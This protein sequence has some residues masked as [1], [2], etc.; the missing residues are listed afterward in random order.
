MMN[1]TPALRKRRL[2]EAL[3]GYGF[4]LPQMAGFV[5]LVLIPLVNVFVYSFH[6]KN[7]LFGTNLFCGFDN[8][9]RLFSDPLFFL[10][11]KNTL[12]FSVFLVPINLALSLAL[13]LYLGEGR[14]GTRYIRTVIFLPV[15]TSGVAWSIVWI[16]LLQGG[17]AGPVNWVLARMGIQGPNWLHEKGW[18]MASVILTRVLKN[19]GTN[20]LVLYGAVVNMDQGVIEAARIDGASGMALFRR[21]KLPMLMPTVLMASIVT[22]IGSMRVFDTIK[23]MT[24][25]GPEGSTMVLVY[26]V[27]YQGFKAYQTGYASAIA[28]ILF[29][30]ML[31]M[32]LL[33]WAAR[34]KVSH[35]EE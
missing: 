2:K 17:D 8:Y 26:Y 4:I 1:K 27:Y 30:I 14:F 31:L 10:T 21:I 15:V 11:L 20:V 35:Y 7:M 5:L 28:V 25:G 16:Y 34:R 9:A 23:L 29:L 32:T 6:N 18:A 24:D 3:A 13:A 33:Q 12:V 19:L 22:M